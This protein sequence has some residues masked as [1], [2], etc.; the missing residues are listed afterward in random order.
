MSHFHYETNPHFVQFPLQDQHPGGSSN[1][2]TSPNHHQIP[3]AHSVAPP[4]PKI[5]TRGRH[6]IDSPETTHDPLSSRP[7]PRSPEEPFPPHHNPNS[8]RPLLS[9][10][11]DQQRPPHRGYASES[12]PRIKPPPST[13]PMHQPG[14]KMTKPMKLSATLCCAI[15]LIILILSGLV[16]LIVYLI[17]RPQTPYFDIS[18]ANLN[19]ANLDMGYVLNGDLT[20]VVNFTNPSKK[21]SLDFSYVMFELYFY[22]NTLLAT[23]HI[24]PFIVP[25]GMSMFTSFHLV[26]SQVP[27][28]TAQ[29][30][31]LQLQLGTGPVVLHMK[32]TFHARSN[33]GS[34]MR[35]SYWL[36]TYCTISLNT[37]P[38]GTMRAS[39]CYTTKR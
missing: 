15:L 22:D 32:G 7:M 9:S 35:Y 4:G 30:Q 29:S 20:V 25:K 31:E 12:T 19:T 24:E 13:R 3:Q 16:L 27:I 21:S 5:K 37:P 23:E 10:P 34:L 6:Q 18:A 14:P 36:H 38:S 11:E 17:N 1:S 39:R 33:L 28:Q 8:A 2:W 26:S